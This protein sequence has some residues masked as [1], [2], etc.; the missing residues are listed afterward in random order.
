MV[1]TIEADQFCIGHEL[2]R[3]FAG[4]LEQ[5]HSWYVVYGV[6][7]IQHVARVKHHSPLSPAKT[8]GA[9]TESG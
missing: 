1:L 4:R 6:I 5:E 7:E 9:R 2:R 8:V 3:C